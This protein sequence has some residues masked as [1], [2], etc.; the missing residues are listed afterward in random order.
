MSARNPENCRCVGRAQAAALRTKLFRARFSAQV[1]GPAALAFFLSGHAARAAGFDEPGQSALGQGASNAGV[2]AGGSLSSMFWNPATIT[3]SGRFAAE[4]GAFGILPHISQQGSSTILPLGSAFG[5][6]SDVGNSVLPALV[7]NGYVSQQIA[8]RLWAGL[9]INAPFGLA[10]RFPNPAWAGAFYGQNASLK[11]YN[12]APTIAIKLTDWISI[13]AGLQA[14][15]AE[16]NLTFVSAILGPGIP[17][18]A[19][20]T[21]AGWGFG[22]TTGVTLTPTATTRIGLGY[23]SAIDQDLNG[24]LAIVGGL[25]TPGS[26]STT[27]KLPGSL[28]LGLRQGLSPQVTLL[29]TVAWTD[30]SRIGTS[31]FTQPGGTLALTPT[32]APISIPFQ[33]RDGW[34]Y[35]TGLEYALN[36][37]WT[38]RGGVAYERSPIT[39]QVRVPLLPDNN[40]TWVSAGTTTH[41]T[42]YLSVDLAYSYIHLNSTPVNVV[43]GNP[44]F[45]GL[46]T[47]VGTANTHVNVVALALRYVF[48]DLPSPPRRYR[49]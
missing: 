40:R 13:G 6:T 33:Y 44:S 34:F 46:V 4:L 36:P 11:T 27:V 42:R 18:L 1:L 32:G 21:A 7:P 20:I 12:I 29:G 15:Y 35:S 3:Q 49:P 19:Q 48:D 43:P 10:D 47:Y 17:A 8:D 30:W 22:W 45:N 5:F 25:S 26:V 2:A 24:S 23:R 9:S 31:N 39:D 16:A 41:V 37:V 14:E 38:L 28:S